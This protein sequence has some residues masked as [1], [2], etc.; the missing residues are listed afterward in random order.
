MKCRLALSSAAVFVVMLLCGSAH[1]VDGVVLIDQ[2]RAAAGHVT[3]H[4]TPGFPVTISTPGSYRLSGNLTVARPNT[5]AIEITSDNVTLDL[6]GFSILGPT[7]CTPG[8]NKSVSCSPSGSGIG[9]NAPTE[10]N[11]TVS[12]GVVS[13]MGLGGINLGGANSRA[14]RIQAYSNGSYGIN[15]T[16]ASNNTAANNG[17]VGITSTIASNNTS[18]NNG[19]DGIDSPGT[20]NNCVSNNNGGIGISA[21]TANNSSST[22]NETSG[23]LANTAIGNTAT[24]NVGYGIE[25]GTANNNFSS[26]NGGNGIVANTAV[27][28]TANANGG[29]GL[30]SSGGYANNVFNGN[31]TG[32]VSGGLQMGTNICNNAACP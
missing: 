18:A 29:Y 30:V 15:A 21:V 16:I 1:A 13:G 14:E 6:N 26:N 17:T 25:A 12:N 23:I 24:G 3:P 10:E 31:T 19:G 5:T 4:D 32:Q 9:V 27:G 8:A 11:I 2:A 22:N 7:V 28:N 20:V